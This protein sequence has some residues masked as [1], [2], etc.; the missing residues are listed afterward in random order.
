VLLGAGLLTAGFFLLPSDDA[1]A[2][3]DPA[4]GGG[5]GAGGGNNRAGGYRRGYTPIFLVTTHSRM[6]T[7]SVASR[8]APG[9]SVARGGF[10]TSGVRISGG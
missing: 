10:G 9:A 2:N 8:T 1:R 6:S 7:A 5:A 4:D 3:E